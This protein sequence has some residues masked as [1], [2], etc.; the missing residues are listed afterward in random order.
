MHE[1]KQDKKIVSVGK[2][3]YEVKENTIFQS[4][5]LYTGD[6]LRL[7]GADPML[8]KKAAELISPYLKS[9][10]LTVNIFDWNENASHR[11][12]SQDIKAIYHS[13]Y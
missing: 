12:P 9:K 3:N 2:D 6:Q 11:W 4:T 7:E 8:S 13:L 5:Y 10:N 1:L